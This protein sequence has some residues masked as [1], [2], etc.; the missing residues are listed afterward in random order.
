MMESHHI[1]NAADSEIQPMDM[2]GDGLTAS[3]DETNLRNPFFAEASEE[4]LATMGPS[5]TPSHETTSQ[6]EIIDLSASR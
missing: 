3:T 1:G 6:V 2:E 5:N 4:V